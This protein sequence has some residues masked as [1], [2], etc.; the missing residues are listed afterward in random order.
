MIDATEI[1]CK[2]DDFLKGFE[3]KFKKQLIKSGRVRNRLSELGI[4]EMMT[5]MILFHQSCYR[6]FKGFYQNYVLVHLRNEFPNLVSYSRF[7]QLM[8]RIIVPLLAFSQS[9]KGRVTGI[10]F[11]DSTSISVCNNKRINRNR[12]FKG[13]ASRGKS[14]MGWF[15]G[16]K[17]HLIVNDKGDLLSWKLTQGNVDDRKPVPSMAKNIKGKLFADKV[18]ISQPLFNALFKNGTHLVMNIRSNM[19]NRLMPIMDR[20]LL[21]KRFIIETINDQLKNIAQVEHSRH[22][23]PMNFLVNLIAGLSAYQLKPKKPSIK[24]NFSQL[25]LQF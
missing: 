22:R 25:S 9:I 8:P 4:S 10:S 2:A 24:L 5:I 15:F 14:T 17:L 7:V 1:F 16:F 23:S 11:V 13:L 18:Y 3:P 21:K 6:H 20:L 12:V 19:K